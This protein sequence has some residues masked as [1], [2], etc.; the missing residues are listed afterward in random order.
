MILFSKLYFYTSLLFDLD[1]IA[2]M[3]IYRMMSRFLF[4]HI[5]HISNPDEPLNS[6]A[7]HGQSLHI[8]RSLYSSDSC[9]DIYN[10]VV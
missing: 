10:I 8:T 4:P 3:I 9:L 5:G 1:N 7:I 6:E 2:F